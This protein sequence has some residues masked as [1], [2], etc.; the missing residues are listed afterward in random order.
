MNTTAATQNPLF[1]I[2]VQKHTENHRSAEYDFLTDTPSNKNTFTLGFCN[3][4]SYA[5]DIF[6]KQIATL[7][8]QVA[9]LQKQSI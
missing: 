3:G 9:E 8:R 4:V 1:A 6:S 2:A 5:S 7:Q